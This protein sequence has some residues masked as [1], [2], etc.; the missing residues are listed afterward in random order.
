METALR[1]Q[2]TLGE[3]LRALGAEELETGN[4]RPIRLEPAGSVWLV[5]N[6]SIELFVLSAEQEAGR[7]A[8]VATL[9]AGELFFG[10]SGTVVLLAVGAP[11]TR[12]LRFSIEKLRQL[13]RGSRWL[14][15]IA[16]K[17]DVWIARLFSHVEH[18]SLPKVFE[19]LRSGSETVLEE[20]KAARSEGGVVWVR[21]VEGRSRFLGRE[22]LVI[23]PASF[24]LPISDQTWLLASEP[25]RLS[26][27][28]TPIVLRGGGLWE[29]LERFHE[30]ALA[31]LARV[32]ERSL[33]TERSRLERRLALDDKV[34]EAAT[35]RLAAVLGTAVSPL[36]DS[37]MG[38][39]A[40]PLLAACRWVGEASGIVFEPPPA[41]KTRRGLAAI[42]AASRVRFRKVILREDWWRRD[43]GPLLGFRANPRTPVA[44]IPTSA[45]SYRLIDP[46]N[47]QRPSIDAELAEGLEGEAYMFYSP[48]PARPL[49]P[50]DLLKLALR[51]RRD[52]LATIFWMGL[53]GGVLGMLIPILTGQIFGEVVPSADRGR[54]FEM[55][56]AL[57]VSALAASAF[58][59]VRSLAMLRLGGKLE[60]TLQAAVWDRLLSLPAGF[61]RRFSVGDL[62][63]RSMG[64][65]AIRNLLIGNVTT[66][67]LAVI[68]SVFSFGLL[69]YYSWQLAFLATGL[70]AVL[71][72][73][74]ALLVYLQLRHQRELLQIQGKV[75]SLLFGLIQG[76]PK[77][78]VGAAEKRA[79]ALWAERF[80]QQRRRAIQAQQVANVQTVF[81]AVYAVLTTLA[82]FSM[83]GLSEKIDL[84][85]ADFLAF[86]AAFGQFQAAALSLVGLFSSFLLV[87][88]I[89]E[90]LEPVLEAVPEVDP[91]KVDAGELAG[92]VEL[93]HVSFRYGDDGPLV[94]DDVSIR[95]KPG[96]FIALVGPSGSGK[97]TC[98]RLLLGFEKP[99]SGSIYY[100][101]QDLPSLDVASVRRQIGVVLQNSRPVVGTI[102]SNILG[103][104]SLG[105]EAAWE[106]ARM[107]GLEED[108]K[109]MPMGMHTVIS[110]G[111]GTFSGG[112]QQRLLIARAL[113]HRPRILLFDEATSALDNRTQEIVS[114]SLERLKATR[115]VVAHRLSTIQ[116]ADR[117]YVIERGRVVEVGRFGELGGS[118][119]AF[120]RLVERQKT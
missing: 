81:N 2:E 47:T 91:S 26:C 13:V 40:D 71:V 39:E 52:D 120:S 16:T 74:T 79:Y 58:Q 35:T 57:V 94:L 64:I 34:V 83:V 114:Q 55:V 78:R 3:A 23:D 73:V 46:E 31:H 116:N 72:G 6:G 67:L 117:I 85:L 36:G 5:E 49:K 37:T 32:L 65:E 115:I 95:A 22:D 118:G 101:G 68:F 84:P 17:I 38:I 110:E 82:I 66:S 97:S 14:T 99:L 89:Y 33:E 19:P 103:A 70:V 27:V 92:D 88:P 63:D 21:H 61:F 15:E 75:A 62:A 113:V 12:L 28:S 56:S 90:R 4:N 77:L 7:R 112:Q 76:L 44:L 8:H 119:G 9:G 98:L 20:N 30:L 102:L 24:L 54:L 107:A 43:N 60:G 41:D 51:G 106:A 104:S 100:D 96:E 108:I 69:F 18:A 42:C 48:L 11:E 87:V 86:N 45:S 53:A 25:T 105:I 80:S 50:W 10:V 111:A 29:G 59:I 1:S 109:N 93:S